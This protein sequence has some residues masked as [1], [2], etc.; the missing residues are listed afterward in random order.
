[1]CTCIQIQAKA[2]THTHTHTITHT[3]VDAKD[4]NGETPLHIAAANGAA[5][6]IK[7]LLKYKANLINKSSRGSKQYLLCKQ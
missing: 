5:E 4:L 6:M 1:M 7:L 3:Q 2:H